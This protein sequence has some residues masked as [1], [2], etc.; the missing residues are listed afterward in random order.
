[1]IRST[2]VD[3]R[4]TQRQCAIDDNNGTE[5]PGLIVASRP[6]VPQISTQVF[7][8]NEFF[9]TALNQ[10]VNAAEVTENIHNGED[11]TYWTASVGG[12]T[13]DFSSTDQANNGDM[14]IDG[15]SA[16]NNHFAIFT[17]P[18][19]T[20]SANN[21]TTLTGAIFIEDWSTG[22][23]RKEVELRLRNNGVNVGAFVGLSS[24]INIGIFNS[25]QSFS[26]PLSSFGLTTQDFDQLTVTN[27]D[28][29]GGPAPNYYL[30]D[31]GLT[32]TGGT[33]ESALEYTVE[34]PPGT[35]L[36]LYQSGIKIVD[37]YAGTLADGTLPNIPYDGILGVGTL[38]N[39]LVGRRIVNGE[40]LFSNV[41]RNLIDLV[42]A[43]SDTVQAFGDGTNTWVTIRSDF[44]TTPVIL[45]SR[46]NDKLSMLV[47]DNLSGLIHFS[48]SYRGILEQRPTEFQ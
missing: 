33:L 30:D 46:N 12:G 7:F 45:D 26:I 29:G 17:R 8:R 47:Q 32:P 16:N 28:V 40:V 15:S 20:I 5:H 37:A 43:T 3:G 42:L 4:G 48:W 2:I 31:L 36:I 25:W 6:L 21:F 10:N 35:R 13:W 39:G 19:G 38:T 14:S 34:P 44:S 11:N 9:G 41:S 23:S 18:G 1:M 22:G 27:I 24:F